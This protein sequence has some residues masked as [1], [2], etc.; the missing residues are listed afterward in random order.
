MAKYNVFK[1][2]Y[3]IGEYE[4]TLAIN[5]EMAVKYFRKFPLYYDCFIKIDEI[6]SRYNES[7]R[8]TSKDVLDIRYYTEEAEIA[9]ESMVKEYL[10]EMLAYAHENGENNDIA[11]FSDYAKKVLAFCEEN[12][13]LYNT[14][15]EDDN[16]ETETFKGFYTLVMEFISLGFIDG[17][18]KPTKKPTMKIIVQ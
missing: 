9:S 11:D 2:K 3:T 12:E 15:Y 1:K 16:G 17:N 5:R 7:E 18:G 6:N 14:V 13:L 8:L 10:G 4:F